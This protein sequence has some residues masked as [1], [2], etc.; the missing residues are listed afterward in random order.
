MLYKRELR[1]ILINILILAVVIFIAIYLVILE[2]IKRSMKYDECYAVCNQSVYNSQ[3]SYDKSDEIKKVYQSC[4][5]VCE[6]NFK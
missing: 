6:N 5:N 1:K 2:P 4:L 3:Q